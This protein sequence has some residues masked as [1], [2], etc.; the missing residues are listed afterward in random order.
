MYMCTHAHVQSY[1]HT[2]APTQTHY[3]H[4]HTENI[5]LRAFVWAEAMLFGSLQEYA[6][7]MHYKTLADNQHKEQRC[8]NAV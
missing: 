7:K 6:N 4:T 8:S 1:N 5:S 3:R 2:K